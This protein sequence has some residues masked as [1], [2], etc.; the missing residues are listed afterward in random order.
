MPSPAVLDSPRSPGA[1][2][3]EEPQGAPAA[4]TPRPVPAGQTFRQSGVT[5]NQYVTINDALPSGN[6]FT[7][8][9]DGELQ[10]MSASPLHEELKSVVALLIYALAH[11]FEIALKPMGNLTLRAN[12]AE[13]GLEPDD[14]YYVGV[15]RGELTG[16]A[17]HEL[18][19]P[20]LALEVEVAAT[21]LD[22]LPIY[23]AL[24][25]EEVWRCD[26]ERGLTFL[27]L[28]GGAG[29]SYRESTESELFPGATPALV[30]EAAVTLPDDEPL[31]YQI[32]AVD[33]FRGRLAS[34]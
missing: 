22:R 17:P 24:G 4:W 3:A 11:H 8:Y 2:D 9:A 16:L 15:R 12:A 27:T 31:S 26:G 30:W 33:F 7:S 6:V 25:V 29:G 23:S 28:D 21:V 32:A 10:L 14:C 19:P 1:T 20:T 5:F 34:E 13:R 18:P